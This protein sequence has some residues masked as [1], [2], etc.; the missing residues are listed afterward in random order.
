MAGYDGYSKSNN[1]RAAESQGRYTATA[2]ARRLKCKSAAIKALIETGEYHHT[3]S[4]YNETLYYDEPVLLALAS[5]DEDEIAEATEDLDP[6]DIAKAK[7][8]LVA[9]RAWK[10]AGPKR[11]T[12]CKVEWLTWGGSRKRPVATEHEATDVDITVS[13]AYITIHLETGDVR[14]KSDSNGTYFT[15]GEPVEC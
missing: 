10:P 15:L 1:A 11:Y 8:L 5:G 13:G 9:L 4:W 14:K 2:L 3:S 12:G 7:D 6:E